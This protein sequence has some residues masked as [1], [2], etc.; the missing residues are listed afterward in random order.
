MSKEELVCDE[1]TSSYS[2]SGGRVFGGAQTAHPSDVTGFCP[3]TVQTSLVK[4]LGTTRRER[5]VNNPNK[6]LN[7]SIMRRKTK[8][9]AYIRTQN[10]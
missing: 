4:V 5:R 7:I 8:L 6:Y 9:I 3:S 1:G 2:S 10:V